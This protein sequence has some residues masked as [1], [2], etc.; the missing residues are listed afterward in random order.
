MPAIS[1][2]PALNA[3]IR[4]DYR[5]GRNEQGLLA[6]ENVCVGPS[7]LYPYEPL[8]NPISITAAAGIPAVEV[9][10]GPSY[11]VALANDDKVYTLADGETDWAETEIT[12]LK[13]PDD[14]GTDLALDSGTNLWH[15]AAFQRGWIAT[16]GICALYAVDGEGVYLDNVTHALCVCS[17][18]GR[19]FWGGLARHW[20]RF[21][22]KGYSL[23][24][25]GQTL[26]AMTDGW[27][28]WCTIQG[29]DILQHVFPERAINAGAG[30]VEAE[31]T[32]NGDFASGS[33][34]W[35]AGSG[36]TFDTDHM[37]AVTASGNLDYRVTTAMAPDSVSAYRIEV[38]ITRSAGS[39]TMSL[40]YVALGV[41][42]EYRGDLTL[43]TS[44]QHV[45]YAHTTLP[46][47][48]FDVRFDGTGFSGTVHSL[49][50]KSSEH[51]DKFTAWE[52]QA[53]LLQN[54]FSPP[55]DQGKVLAIK[56]LYD[57][58]VVYGENWI[59]AYSPVSVPSPTFGKSRIANFGIAGRRAV[60]G[61]LGRHVLCDASGKLW[62]LDNQLKLEPIGHEE[63]FRSAA[64]Y[65]GAS[66][67]AISYDE[68]SEWVYI[69]A[70]TGDRPN[71]TT[72]VLT[73]GGLSEVRTELV[74]S[75][76]G[77]RGTD[78]WADA[79]GYA[80]DG[81]SDE[82]FLLTDVTDFNDGNLKTIK[83]VQVLGDGVEN[84]RVAVWF[85]NAGDAQHYS[86]P[87][88][89]CNSR[90]EVFTEQSGYAFQ[91]AL[92]ADS[93]AS[94]RIYDII[95]TYESGGRVNAKSVATRR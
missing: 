24:M 31:L 25:W 69:S 58:V 27:I 11:I 15:F 79:T 57:H 81:E 59:T 18:R 60:G 39:L 7:G 44:G 53:R 90:G 38:D 85:R 62:S 23:D 72:F 32:E 75:V 40:V 91:F 68:S 67:L 13:S 77:L 9:F 16:N 6:L 66:S 26:D 28:G 46:G 43:D 82:F 76:C 12:L 92:H 70:I 87:G 10:R 34:G 22:A 71:G 64:E 8:A 54:G 19:I 93:Y 74:H 86:G 73:A 52:E 42:V 78:A 63:I 17:F 4:R 33:T 48:A 95:V 65:G 88:A 5:A 20:L 37:N 80:T 61:N 50:V 14:T 36:W 30:R 47:G 35:T 21:N 49:S 84:I 41:T 3:G 56:A 51:F 2:K 55:P 1:L 45:F 83:S 29:R 89:M 94:V